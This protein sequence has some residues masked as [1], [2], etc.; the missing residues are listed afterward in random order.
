MAEPYGAHLS[1]PRWLTAL[2]TVDSAAVAHSGPARSSSRKEA[3]TAGCGS[4]GASSTNR[5]SRLSPGGSC[6]LR[7]EVGGN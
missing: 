5:A 6:C 7:R 2:S 1:G 3:L 4:A